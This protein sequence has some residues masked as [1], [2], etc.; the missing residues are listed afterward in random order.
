[1]TVILLTANGQTEVVAASGRR[2]LICLCWRKL[3]GSLGG[4]V[5]EAEY[6]PSH[7]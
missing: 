7:C 5:G 4:K 3:W 1:M 2:W 6:V